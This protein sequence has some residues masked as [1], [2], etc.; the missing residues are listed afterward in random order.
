MK[1]DSLKYATLELV[2]CSNAKIRNLLASQEH[3]LI[4]HQKLYS[5]KSTMALLVTS[6]VLV[7][8]CLLWFVG[9]YPS[10]V[11]ALKT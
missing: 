8:V 7:S 6:G 5:R 10:E 2:N 9:Q 4:C 11:N 3:L 1:K